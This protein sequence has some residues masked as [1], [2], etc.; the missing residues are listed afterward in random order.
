MPHHG[1]DPGPR[2]LRH[3]DGN[4]RRR[5]HKQYDG[6]HPHY[7]SH[8]AEQPD[9]GR[10]NPGRRF[11]TCH[12]AGSQQR[13][14]RSGDVLHRDLDPRRQDLHLLRRAGLHRD[15]VDQR[16]CLHLLG[17]GQQRQRNQ[18]TLLGLRGDHPSDDP[19]CADRC[20][21]QQPWRQRQHRSGV[22]RPRQRWRVSDHRLPHPVL[23]RQRRDV[24]GRRATRV[25]GHER[26]ADRSGRQ[27]GLR[28]AC[29]GG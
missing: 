13:R 2:L 29:G 8:R 1:P 11:S 6:V 20:D 10:W 4:Q 25:G 16:H 14:R 5:P 23:H 21:G 12:V 22:D 7:R 15:R 9:P 18:H 3:P 26:H 17:D 28:V 27:P 19:R 24:D